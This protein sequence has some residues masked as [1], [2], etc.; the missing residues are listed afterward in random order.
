[1][2]YLSHAFVDLIFLLILYS[3]NCY[4]GSRFTD[5]KSEQLKVQEPAPG[6]TPVGGVC[7][8]V[9]NQ[10]LKLPPFRVL[11]CGNHDPGIIA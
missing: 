5:G 2:K 11:Y 8:I 3:E 10:S 6:P 7:G 4:Y 1:M 9:V